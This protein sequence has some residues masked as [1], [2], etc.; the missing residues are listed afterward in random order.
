MEFY[1]VS[2]DIRQRKCVVV[3]GGKVAL[4][5]VCKLFAA[6]AEV[7][8]I[9][10]NFSPD[11]QQNV[12]FSQ[13]T[14]ISQKYSKEVLEGAVLVFAAT[15]DSAVNRQVCTDAK[16]LGIWANSADGAEY[17]S[18]IVP[19]SCYKD[20]LAIGITTEGKA[21]CLSKQL[22]KYLQ[23]KLEQVSD[24]L[25]EEIVYLRAQKV[26]TKDAKEKELL[27]QRMLA[28][29]VAIIKQMEV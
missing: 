7:I 25:I 20:V 2:I 21:P 15:S 14:I 18:F 27:E 4:R 8:A 29:T 17:S 3:G 5:K 10:P 23:E 13:I 9:A 12:V 6:G 16:A 28:K 22:R 26:I 24:S 11:F 19:A 1:N